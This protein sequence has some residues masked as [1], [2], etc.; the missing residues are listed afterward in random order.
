[1]T[2]I[3]FNQTL[4][5]FA[6]KWFIKGNEHLIKDSRFFILEYNSIINS[7]CEQLLIHDGLAFK[8][9]GENIP[10]AILI[11]TFGVKGVENLLE[12]GAIEFLLWNPGV[13]YAIDDIP[14]IY[15]LQSMSKFTSS[16]HSDPEASI[17]SGLEFLRVPLP[18][19]MRRHITRRAL[20]DIKYL[21]KISKDATDFG[22]K[23][24]N[25]NLFQE[26]GLPK[27]KNLLN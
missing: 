5:D 25:D 10:L 23:G 22:H 27:K 17:K 4:N 13:T 21:L 1:M 6:R 8:V 24:Y 18:R 19:R 2:K 16:V 11:N 26:F 7:I 9:Y 15:P 3:V 14:G 20:K 12:E